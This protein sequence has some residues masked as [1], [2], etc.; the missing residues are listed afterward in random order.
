MYKTDDTRILAIH[1]T[2]INMKLYGVLAC[3]SDL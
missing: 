3:K 1:N 2:L